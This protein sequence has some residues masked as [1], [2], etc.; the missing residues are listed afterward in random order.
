MRVVIV[1]KKWVDRRWRELQKSYSER[2]RGIVD[3]LNIELLLRFPSSSRP[4]IL[5][6]HKITLPPPSWYLQFVPRST[7]LLSPLKSSRIV[8]NPRP[9][10]PRHAVPPLT[11]VLSLQCNTLTSQ[12]ITSADDWFTIFVLS[13]PTHSLTQS[14]FKYREKIA[15]KWLQNNLHIIILLHS[16]VASSATIPPLS[17]WVCVCGSVLNK[18]KHNPRQSIDSTGSSSSK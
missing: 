3:Y 4:L 13:F 2:C 14:H 17:P 11:S 18:Q 15:V 6:N 16:P 1:E 8:Q 12:L 7:E 9:Q 10:I 5:T